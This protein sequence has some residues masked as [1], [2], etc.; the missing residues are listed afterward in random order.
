[1]RLTDQ[2]TLTRNDRDLLSAVVDGELV[3]MSV[4]RG[5]CYGLNEVATRI[6]GLLAEPRTLSQL[7]EALA[8]EYEVDPATC[9]SDV[10]SHLLEMQ[11]AG[12]IAVT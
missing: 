8:A 7:C 4:E 10:E 3:G 9:R 12:L 1:M 2:S 6:W 11:S 5:T